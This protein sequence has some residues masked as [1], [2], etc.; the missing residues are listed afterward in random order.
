M[1]TS[2][3]NGGKPEASMNTG[4]PPYRDDSETLGRSKDELI[5]EFRNLINDGEALLKSTTTLSGEALAQARAQ[6]RARL[7]DART[8]VDEVSRTAR[9]KG[10]QAAVATDRYVHDNPWPAIG[11][12][13]GLGLVIGYLAA[14]RSGDVWDPGSARGDHLSG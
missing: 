6:F 13:V 3:S 7:A 8:R 4:A 9:E 10:R 5:K 11:A 1:R 12:A 14:R 2:T